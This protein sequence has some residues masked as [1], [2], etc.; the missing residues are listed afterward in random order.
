MILAEFYVRM[1]V[2]NSNLGFSMRT[3]R[4]QGDKRILG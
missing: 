2:L 3:Q 4:S 1:F